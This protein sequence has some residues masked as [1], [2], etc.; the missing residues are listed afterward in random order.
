MA[1]VKEELSKEDI[2]A[3]AV[4][5]VLSGFVGEGSCDGLN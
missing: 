5:F 3:R 1:N 4:G 2:I